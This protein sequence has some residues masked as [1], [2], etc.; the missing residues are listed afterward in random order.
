MLL[1]SVIDN[2]C[3]LRYM[4]E[5]LQL[6]S[7]CGRDA[8]LNAPMMTTAKELTAYYS[9]LYEVYNTLYINELQEIGEKSSLLAM[10]K[11]KLMCLRD[12]TGTLKRLEAEVVL[13]DI[14]LFEIKY[15]ALMGEAVGE[16][17]KK[18]GLKGIEIPDLEDVIKILDPDGQKIESFYVYDSYSKDLGRVRSELKKLQG[19]DTAQLSDTQIVSKTA[20]EPTN[21]RVLELL[22]KEQL[23]ERE[24]REGLSAKLRSRIREIKA[25]LKALADLD[26]LLAKALQIKMLGL[27]FP[28]IAAKGADSE[29]VTECVTEYKGMF[30]PYIVALYKEKEARYGKKKSFTPID[31]RFG[32]EAVTIIGANMGGKTVVLKMTALNQFLF[33]FGF[34]IAAKEATI[35]IKDEIKVCIGDTQNDEEGL[36][37]FAGEVRGINDVLESVDRGERILALI[38]EPARTTN[39][40]EGTALVSALMTVLKEKRLSVLL[41]THYNIKGDHFKR[42]RVRGLQEN[43]AMDYRLEEAKTGDIPREAINVA[44]TLNINKLWLQEAEKELSKA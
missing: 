16:I 32:L 33:Q 26:I 29:E 6:Q 44:K 10:L 20:T 43:G 18:L 14:D 21:E 12:I 5:A 24:I 19:T 7:S 3:G 25:A 2:P 34:G 35:D 39:P 8:L 22:E 36:S 4:F 41:T 17:V 9:K 28:K 11:H 15:L 23:M 1:K 38:D 42:L 31:I 27:C 13:D 37:S 40:I 30:H